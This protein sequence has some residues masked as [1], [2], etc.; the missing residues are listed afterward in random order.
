MIYS[1]LL[2]IVC[3]IVLMLICLAAARPLLLAIAPSDNRDTVVKISLTSL[4]ISSLALPFLPLQFSTLGALLGFQMLF[5]IAFV[6]ALWSVAGLGITVYLLFLHD[7]TDKIEERVDD[8]PN[9]WNCPSFK[10]FLIQGAVAFVGVSLGMSLHLLWRLLKV[11]KETKCLDENFKIAP[12]SYP[13]GEAFSKN[14]FGTSVRSTL[15]NVQG[16]I[17]L[18]VAFRIGVSEAACLIMFKS[19]SSASYVVPNLLS[20]PAMM[21]VPR[22]I[23]TKQTVA[24]K[25]LIWD[26]RLFALGTGLV[27]GLVILLQRDNLIDQY[28]NEAET[29]DFR[30]LV[31]Q[32]WWIFVLYQPV[33]ALLAVYGPLISATQAFVFWGQLAFV[34]FIFVFLPFT[35]AGSQTKRI[36]LILLGVVMTDLSQAIGCLVRVH[37]YE[38]PQLEKEENDDP[39]V[40]N[41]S[42]DL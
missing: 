12:G 27:F 9:S 28:A 38:I 23:G 1:S 41:Q 32:T 24:A 2:A 29:G 35:I 3:G 5:R 22:L 34:T 37:I 21:S 14:T 20:V 13:G 18:A 25:R 33:H 31:H 16:F 40:L 30:R 4:Y 26:Y 36:I 15:N 19:V 6:Y 17:L 7:C 42:S 8:D 10:P 39:A 11:A